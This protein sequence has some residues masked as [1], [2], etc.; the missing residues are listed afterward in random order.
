MNLSIRVAAASLLM[1]SGCA[2]DYIPQPK[3]QDRRAIDLCW[4]E[5]KRKSL[6]PQQQ[7]FIAGAC[8]LMERNFTQKYG[9][10]P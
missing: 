1:L 6:D 3:E 8:E 7:R 4:E 10:R 2:D 5:Q 9:Q